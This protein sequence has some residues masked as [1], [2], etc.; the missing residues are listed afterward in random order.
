M[1]KIAIV[2]NITIKILIDYIQKFAS[3]QQY[4]HVEKCNITVKCGC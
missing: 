1:N 4:D 2:K 3:G